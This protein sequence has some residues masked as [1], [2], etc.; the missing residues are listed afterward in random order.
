MRS[1]SFMDPA[2][3]YTELKPT[4]CITGIYEPVP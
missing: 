3:D 1:L 2:T 4:P